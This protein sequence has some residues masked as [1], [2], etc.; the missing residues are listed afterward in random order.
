VNNFPLNVDGYRFRII[1][2]QTGP[3]AYRATTIKETYMRRIFGITLFT[4][5]VGCLSTFGQGCI[6]FSAS[7]SSVGA[8]FTVPTLSAP[9]ATANTAFF[10]RSSGDVSKAEIAT[11]WAEILSDPKFTLAG[12]NNSREVAVV[13]TR[14]SAVSNYSAPHQLAAE[15]GV[16]VGLVTVF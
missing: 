2:N 9:A 7:K 10:G 15:F 4:M 11:S 8:G 12:Y 16:A 6:F 13:K 3:V 14:P 5:S 1:I